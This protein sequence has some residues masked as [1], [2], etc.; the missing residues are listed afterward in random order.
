MYMEVQRKMAVLDWCRNDPTMRQILE[1][2]RMQKIPIDRQMNCKSGWNTLTSVWRQVSY[3][4]T[5][6]WIPIRG[7]FVVFHSLLLP[8]A[9]SQLLRSA[10]W[11]DHDGTCLKQSFWSSSLHFHLHVH[12]VSGVHYFRFFCSSHWYVSSLLVNALWLVCLF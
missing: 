6:L 4:L 10:S 3:Y 12:D 2:V 9:S 1:A 7:I 8:F 5:S 11:L